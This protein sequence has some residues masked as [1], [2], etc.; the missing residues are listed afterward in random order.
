MTRLQRD[1]QILRWPGARR[2]LRAVG[3]VHKNSVLA[4][5]AEETAYVT[6]PCPSV[7][8]D[9]VI[10]GDDNDERWLHPGIPSEGTSPR[11]KCLSNPLML[12]QR[13]YEELCYLGDAVPPYRLVAHCAQKV[14]EV[15]VRLS[16]LHV[17]RNLAFDQGYPSPETG[18]LQYPFREG[19]SVLLH[20][21]RR[22]I[23]W[24]CLT[25]SK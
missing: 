22:W 16:H 12:V 24:V 18:R 8:T 7:K 13:I 10:R 19:I 5:D 21:A 3:F 14:A 20:I 4:V 15:G 25:H 11:E 9:C 23:T 1:I 6:H 17:A 2:P